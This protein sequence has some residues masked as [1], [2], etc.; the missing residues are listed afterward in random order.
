MCLH[1]LSHFREIG[2]SYFEYEAIRLSTKMVSYGPKDPYEAVSIFRYLAVLTLKII[3]NYSVKVQAARPGFTLEI[4]IW[5]SFYSFFEL[6]FGSVQTGLNG[7]RR[8][9]ELAS[10]FSI[11][12]AGYLK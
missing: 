2:A 10:N 12:Q 6:P 9:A 7:A 3:A 11:R 5:T 8:H 1:I 4:F